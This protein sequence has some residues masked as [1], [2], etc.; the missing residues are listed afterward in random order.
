[1][2]KVFGL[3]LIIALVFFVYN[4][5]SA[6][7]LFKNNISEITATKNSPDNKVSSTKNKVLKNVVRYITGFIDENPNEKE[8][9]KS[10]NTVTERSKQNEPI[11]IVIDD[12]EY[13]AAP[14]DVQEK[15]DSEIKQK[16]EEY[17]SV[18]IDATAVVLCKAKNPENCINKVSDSVCATQRQNCADLYKY[19]SLDTQSLNKVVGVTNTEKIKIN[20]ETLKTI[21]SSQGNIQFNK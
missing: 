1:M 6:N 20:E 21:G 2:K 4:S 11:T 10:H 19:E 8:S 18:Q 9:S 13:P 12:S 3:I 15:I 17:K 14:L 16:K 7:K 5:N